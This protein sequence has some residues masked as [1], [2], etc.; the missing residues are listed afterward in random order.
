M[1]GHPAFAVALGALLGIALT[2]VSERAARFVTPEDPTRGFAM[3]IVMMG[4]RFFV[5]LALLAVYYILAPAGLAPFGMALALSF[6][7]GLF[8]E[9]VR[10]IRPHVPHT[11]A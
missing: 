1:I 3:V 7:A 11:S 2:L 10:I 4:A 8:V 5:S 9:A 6:V